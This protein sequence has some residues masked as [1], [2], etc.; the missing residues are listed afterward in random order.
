M[1]RYLEDKG[2]FLYETLIF[3]SVIF[4]IVFFS[5]LSSG[6][7]HAAFHSFDSAFSGFIAS[8]ITAPIAKFF[9]FFTYLGNT[10]IIFSIECCV[11]L[12][13]LVFHHR[14]DLVL[15]MS[16]IFFGQI[17]SFL[18]KVIA[19]RPRPEDGML[20]ILGSDSFPSGH[21]IMAVVFYGLIAYLINRSIGSKFKRRIVTAV[22][23]VLVFLIGFSR[24]YLGVHWLSDVVA[25]WAL[26]GVVLSLFISI[27]ERTKHIH[28][29]SRVS[30]PGHTG[31]AYSQILLGA[32]L[33]SLTF[34]IVY[35]Y[36]SHP[37]P[38]LP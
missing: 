35:F 4:L 18:F 27:F 19:E 24:V 15:F 13:F 6:F 29:K 37:L 36:V 22:A 23:I 8:G 25:G 7:F 17:L 1:K 12:I 26:G 5:I 32:L 31:I 33:A 21:A 14:R 34:F 28:E 30:H 16:S 2:H 10:E 20:P 11:I 38:L 3:S 9:L